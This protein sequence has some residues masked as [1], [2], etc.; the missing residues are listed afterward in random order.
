MRVLAV[1]L[2]DQVV[3]RGFAPVHLDLVGFSNPV[4]DYSG[5]LVASLRLISG[6]SVVRVLAVCSFDLTVLR[7]SAQERLDLS[8]F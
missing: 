7:S 6:R 5:L 3:Q 1:G 4:A 8:G 2:F